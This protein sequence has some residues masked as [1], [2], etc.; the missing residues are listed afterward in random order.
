MD[1]AD[2]I[3]KYSR[4][5]TPGGND[6]LSIAQVFWSTAPLD[7]AVAIYYVLLARGLIGGYGLIVAGAFLLL[8]ATIIGNALGFPQ[9]R[10][11]TGSPQYMLAGFIDSYL[12]VYGVAACLS[13]IV[14]G[15]FFG[16]S[17]IHLTKT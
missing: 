16:R 10:P 6:V 4:P 9:I 2:F 14:V 7:V 15:I 8:G 1:T 3:L 5:G 17:Y 11:S 12:T 13:A